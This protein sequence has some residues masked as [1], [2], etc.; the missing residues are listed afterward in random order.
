MVSGFKVYVFKSISA[1]T[2]FAPVYTIEF[3]LAINVKGD[4]ITSSPG[5]TSHASSAV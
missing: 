5:P 4:V 2:G 1:K 3:P